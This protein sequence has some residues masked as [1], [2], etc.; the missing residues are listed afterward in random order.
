MSW[1]RVR[2]LTLV[3]VLVAGGAG[4]LYLSLLLQ[5]RSDGMTRYVRVDVWA[6]QLAE[7]DLQQFRTA[8]ARHVAGDPTV[9][10]ADLRELFIRA[11]SAM[12]LLRRNPNFDDV[13]SLVAINQTADAV[14]DALTEIGALMAEGTDLRGDLTRLRSIEDLLEQP[15][16]SLR[17]L[18]FDLAQIRLELQDQD[19]GNMRWLA[20]INVRMLLGF[21]LV[22][23]LFI[24]FLLSETRSAKKSETEAS[25]ARSRLTEAIENIDEGFALYDRD[26][27]LIL[28]NNRFREILFESNPPDLMG[29]SIQEVMR[30]HAETYQPEGSDDYTEDWLEAYIAYHADP[31]GVFKLQLNNGKHLQIAERETFDGGRVAIFTD[32]TKLKL[33]EQELSHALDEAELANR[34]KTEFLANMSHEL[35]TPLNAIIGF[36]EIFKMEMFGPLGA[37]QYTDYT[38]DIHESAQHLLDVINDILDVS[39]IEQ[40]QLELSEDEFPLEKIVEACTRLVAERAKAAGHA[41]TVELPEESIK[42]VADQRKTKQ[43]LLNLLSNAIKFTPDG[44]R[45]SLTAEI[46]EEGGLEIRIADTGI[47]MA[48]KD[49]PKVL[50]SFGQADSQ[51]ARKYEGTG[52]GLPLAKSFVEA[53]GGSLSLSSEVDAGTTVAVRFPAARVTIRAKAA[54]RSESEVA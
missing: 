2:Y 29:S 7:H 6:V 12:P 27:R 54:E 51:L 22:A 35:R 44:G 16:F 36:S 8:F 9:T 25:E 50:A 10:R 52:L 47:G 20:G 17:Q 24:L 39:R 28:C 33:H 15:L 42:L 53:H 31:S 34:S 43:I 32:I 46:L 49:V 48:E 41:L 38:N 13:R 5:Q 30:L 37:A 3:L 19:I 18:E 23:L 4:A 21:F 14:D 40:G 11:E 26:D 45:I 1:R